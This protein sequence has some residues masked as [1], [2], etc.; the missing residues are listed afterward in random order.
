MTVKFT[1]EMALLATL[2]CL[3]L[4]SCTRVS[5]KSDV[6]ATDVVPVRAV[7]AFA[8]DIPLEITAVGNVEAINRVD[9][10]SRI[11]GQIT[12]VAFEEGQSVT[13]GQLL[14]SIDRSTLERQA[15]EQQ[16]DLQR[17]TAMEQQA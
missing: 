17:D 12:R 15:A 11:A 4:T 2:A 7:R 8:Q 16:A 5:A 13:K 6:P 14:F 9:V 3:P 1:A 10:K